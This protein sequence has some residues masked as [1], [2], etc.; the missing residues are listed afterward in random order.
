[1]KLQEYIL[2]AKKI[3]KRTLFIIEYHDNTCMWCRS[4]HSDVETGCA[5]AGLQPEEDASIRSGTLVNGCRS[6]SQKIINC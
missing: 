1:M 2:C 6:L 4:Q 5:A 3:N